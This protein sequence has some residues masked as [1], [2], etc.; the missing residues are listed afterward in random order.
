MAILYQFL[1]LILFNPVGIGNHITRFHKPV[2]AR[3]TGSSCL[4]CKIWCKLCSC[5]LGTRKWNHAFAIIFWLLQRDIFLTSFY[6]G[7][8]A[9]DFCETLPFT[10]DN[11]PLAG[12]Y[13][14]ISNVL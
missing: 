4:C 2:H 5:F 14:P 7:L 1:I 6:P 11:L 13:F 3:T 8:D 10:I 12:P 9:V